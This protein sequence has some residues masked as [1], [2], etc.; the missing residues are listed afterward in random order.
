MVRVNDNEVDFT[1]V[2]SFPIRES[3]P[4]LCITM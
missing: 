3:Q 4:T 2:V 1:V